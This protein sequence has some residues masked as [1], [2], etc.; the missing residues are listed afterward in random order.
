M[1]N[2]KLRKLYIEEFNNL[3]SAFN[4]VILKKARVWYISFKQETRSA[5]KLHIDN[6]NG[7]TN[8][9]N[10]VVIK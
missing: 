2:R 10:P 8:L 5:Y 1:S 3:P 9:G 6:W 4:I 7:R